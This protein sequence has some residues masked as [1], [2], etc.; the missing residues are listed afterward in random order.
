MPEM[1]AQELQ[2]ELKV[3][4]TTLWRWRKE[5]MPYKQYGHRTIRYDL[6]EVKKWLE[7][8]K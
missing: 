5:G 6:N 3:S 4:T 1:T 8:N 7:A 2:E